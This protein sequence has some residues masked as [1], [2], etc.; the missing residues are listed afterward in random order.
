MEDC[1]KY[2]LDEKGNSLYSSSEQELET[3]IKDE[4]MKIEDHSGYKIVKEN[5][6]VY[7]RQV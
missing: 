7:K 1:S 5:G 3:S 4:I 2:L 6:D